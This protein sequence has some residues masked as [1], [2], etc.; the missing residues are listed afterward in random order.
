MRVPSR[1][2]STPGHIVCPTCGVGELKAR[3]LHL[4]IA[5]CASCSV[6]VESAI[7]RTLEQIAALPEA[8]GAHACECG[9]PEMRHLPD[10]V[11]H[12]PACG[13]EVVPLRAHRNSPG[14]PPRS[15][16]SSAAP[17]PGDANAS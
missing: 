11:F 6:S 15:L 10:G 4:D 5:G 9:L 13:A 17:R 12:C 16:R 8:M 7:I 14:N 3:N 1:A 2:T